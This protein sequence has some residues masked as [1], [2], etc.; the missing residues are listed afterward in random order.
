[1]KFLLSMGSLLKKKN[2][3]TSPPLLLFYKT[4]I[5]IGKTSDFL[6]N[7]ID[8][9]IKN[10]LYASEHREGAQILCTIHNLK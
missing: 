3:N 9:D 1:M 4:R 6:P 8:S 10:A 7:L 5:P 2:L